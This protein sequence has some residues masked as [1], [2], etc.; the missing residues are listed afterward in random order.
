MVPTVN[1]ADLARRI[2][3]AELV[4]YPDAGH[5][6]IFQNHVDFVPKALSFLAA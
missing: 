6:G 3:G 5:G 2:P 1:S 4:I